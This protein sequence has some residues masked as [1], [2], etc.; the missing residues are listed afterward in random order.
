M[1]NTKKLIVGGLVIFVAGFSAGKFSGP[2]EKEE[3]TQAD[4]KTNVSKD[5]STSTIT[6]TRPDGTKIITVKQDTKTN[7]D[8]KTD[9]KETEKIT[10]QPDWKVALGMGYNFNAKQEVYMLSVDKRILG[11]I[12]VGVF[13]LTDKTLGVNVQIEF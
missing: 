5:I 8:T 10:N 3:Q 6:E 1:E 11:G 4:T 9:I 2:K 7:I 12:S 13:A